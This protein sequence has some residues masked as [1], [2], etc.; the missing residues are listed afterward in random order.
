[1]ETNQ[2]IKERKSKDFADSRIYMMRCDCHGYFYIGSTTRCLSRRFH[3]HKSDAKTHPDQLVYK[4]FNNCGWDNVKIL[5]LQDLY[6][7]NIE[8]LRKAE[9][10]AIQMHKDDMNCLNQRRAF[11]TIEERIEHKKE[12]QKLTKDHIKEQKKE[13]YEN[14]KDRII[15]K[16]KNY[17]E[18]NRAKIKNYYE[19]NK[20]RYF[21]KRKEY[22]ENHKD[23]ILESKKNYHE[24]NK[25]KINEARS[26]KL[27]CV[28][29]S[30]VSKRH[31]ARHDSSKKHINFINSLQQTAETI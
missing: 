17:R 28:C 14:N 7:D 30:S 6:L 9:D 29:G 12:Y 5:L 8:Q 26:V 27:I 18:Q 2:T 16:Q 3:S 22:Y 4:T 23:E 25:E 15:E 24:Q 10:D 13:Y 11:V 19:N 21:D 31:I 1:M 20:Y